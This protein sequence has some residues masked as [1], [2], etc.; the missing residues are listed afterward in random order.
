MYSYIYNNNSE[1]KMESILVEKFDRDVLEY[2]LK[3]EEYFKTIIK[4]D[5]ESKYDPFDICKKYLLKASGKNKNLVNV[6]YYKKYNRGRMFADN[7]LSLQCIPREIRGSIASSI[8]YDIDMIN[9]H[10]SIVFNLCSKLNK[11]LVYLPTYINKR[12][13]VINEL[14][15][16]N[17]DLDYDYIK[18]T[19]LSCIYGGSTKYNN[20]KNKSDWLIGF[21]KECDKILNNI[22][23]WYKDDFILQ[24]Q[25]KGKN[26]HNLEGSTLSSVVCVIENKLLHI[27]IDYLKQK[28]Y[29]KKM[30]VLCFDGI[31]IPKKISKT[32]L[33]SVDNLNICLRE[34]E[35]LFIN[36]GFDVKLKIKDFSKLNLE[37]PHI[38]MKTKQI[39]LENNKKINYSDLYLKSEY[40]WYDFRNDM[41]KIFN[42][43][44]DLKNTFIN[45]IHKVMMKIINQND[46][47]Y[48][49][50]DS[51]NMFK[52]CLKYPKEVYKYL[53]VFEDGS[54]QINNI[55]LT[56]LLNTYGLISELRTYNALDFKPYSAFNPLKKHEIN[57]RNINTWTGFKA[58]LIPEPE[59]DFKKIKMILN[60]IK[61]V[62][63]SN[64]ITYYNYLISWFKKIFT[65]PSSKTKVAVVL[66][67]YEKQIGKGILIN[68]FLIPYIFGKLYSM[69]I[70]GLDTI[71]SKFNKNLMNKIFINCDELSTLNGNFHQSFDC[72][73]NR[74][75]DPTLN[76]EIKCGDNFIYPDYS[77]YIMSTNH[78]FTIK[79]EPDDQRYFIMECS[80]Y[81]RGNHKYFNEL[82]ETF[83]SETANHFFSYI[84]YFKTDIEIK[85]IPMTNIKKEMMVSCLQSS[86]RF[87]I[88][89]N[90][91]KNILKN[92]EGFEGFDNNNNTNLISITGGFPLIDM[93]LKAKKL[94]QLY[95][96]WCS[97]N[98]E[99][100]SSNTKFGR[101]IKYYIDKKRNSKGVEYDLSTIKFPFLEQ[102]L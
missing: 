2:I 98:C 94:Y 22:K 10:P 48:M 29:L 43:I 21:K 102:T 16:I 49:K 59:I 33:L 62:W 51:D 68:N 54:T 70:S 24:S 17:N 53:V 12:D 71:T 86:I 73:K 7:K 19:I 42:S 96:F 46:G 77:N 81:F 45:N 63:C 92:T 90:D 83:N 89:L 38:D 69:S 39:E 6:H 50:I 100:M 23:E 41:N 58:K 79:I 97:N 8:Y 31:M 93:N 27:M 76:I 75:T 35:K 64:N 95:K 67:S 36:E 78:D 72:L 87:L 30:G 18:S 88:Y 85:K 99:K 26:Y 28:N 44:D 4:I 101:D 80:P 91:K 1:K 65:N 34:I 57:D 74:I 52:Y 56:K 40:Y 15:N 5:D 11:I 9:A 66:K 13:I 14:L 61:I 37:I 84:S 47:I 20:I 60:H 55:S 25:I 3:Y 32:K 82:L